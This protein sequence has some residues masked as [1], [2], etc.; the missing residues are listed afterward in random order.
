MSKTRPADAAKTKM[1]D[2][3]LAERIK[4]ELRE[5][6]CDRPRTH[7]WRRPRGGPPLEAEP[8]PEVEPLALTV[9][10]AGRLLG[11]SRNGSYEAAQRGDLPT[12]R[13]GARI[14]VPRRALDELLNSAVVNWRQRQKMEV[15]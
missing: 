9:P 6:L 2:A 14:I 12:I 7:G 13:I 15:A 10:Q 11:L 1:L 4:R 5:D 8:P 3:G